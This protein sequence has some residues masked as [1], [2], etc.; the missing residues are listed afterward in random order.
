MTGRPGRGYACLRDAT[1]TSSIVSPCFLIGPNAV[2]SIL[3]VAEAVINDAAS[4]GMDKS[5]A[6]E[7]E[8]GKEKKRERKMERGKEKERGGE[9]EREPIC[10]FLLS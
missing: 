3:K 4:H 6:E 5:W 10:F 2:S 1:S 7:T 8:R 9:R